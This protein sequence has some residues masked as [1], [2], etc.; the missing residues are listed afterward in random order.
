DLSEK[1]PIYHID[2]AFQGKE[3]VAKIEKACKEAKP[4]ALAFVDMRMPPGWDGLITIERA[5]KIDPDLQVVICTAHADYSWN[6][7]IERLKN[8]N[9]LLILKKPFENIEVKQLARSLTEKWRLISNLND[10]TRKLKS[11][12]ENLAITL[13]S[14]ADAVIATTPDGKI[15]RMNPAAED[16]TGWSEID[17]LQSDIS[18]VLNL[19]NVDKKN[20]V[21]ELTRYVLTHDKTIALS[22]QVVLA[23]RKGIKFNIAGSFAPMKDADGITAGMVIVFR[24]MTAEK[25]AEEVI[26]ELN[27]TLEQRVR[28]RTASLEAANFELKKAKEIADAATIAKSNFLANM[29]HEIRTPMNGIIAAADLALEET[30]T[31]KMEH[32]LKII[33]SSSYSLLGVINDILDFSKIE[34]GKLELENKEF[35]FD[36]IVDILISMFADKVSKKGIEFVVDI[37]SSLPMT[38][39]GDKLRVQQIITNLMGNAYKFTDKHGTIVF[40]IEKTGRQCD[41]NRSE[42]KFSICDTGVGMTSE[43]LAKIF[44]PF[45]QVDSSSTRK[46]GGTGLG[47]SI[48]RQ[49]IEIMGGKI[50]AE[51][52]PGVGT[53]FYF[54]LILEWISERPVLFEIPSD[55]KHLSI[56]VV[57]DSK[58][59]LESLRKTLKSFG[60]VT[61]SASSGAEALNR[62]N[63]SLYGEESFDLIIMDLNMPEMDGIETSRKIRNEIKL[64]TPIVIMNAFGYETT[65][66]TADEGFINGYLSKPFNAFSVFEAIL[67]VFN[68]GG[69]INQAVGNDR[70]DSLSLYK[71][72]IRGLKILVAED[73][74]TNQEIIQAI[75]ESAG[76]VSEI[77]NNGK[78]AVQ[79]LMKEQFDAVLMDMQMPEM[80]GYEAT[81]T[82]REKQEF[83]SLPI[84]ALTAHALKGDEEKCL[85]AGT[86]AYV[87]KPI[88]QDVLFR[89]LYKEL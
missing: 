53:T 2:S 22:D 43:Q 73:N 14:I 54:T 52:T 51:S 8:T 66:K 15:I 55:L 50:W 28:D 82:I 12:Q 40:R 86:N 87:A 83:D 42:L 31:S 60:L 23:T 34:A 35:G 44:Q 37:D 76:I 26:K 5:W 62:L 19:Q 46:Y 17:A 88:Q 78:E 10:Q 89:V 74:L 68:K 61:E 25:K 47:L 65:S 80:D 59:S 7:I 84:I 24:D 45:T 4:Y 33:H 16:L 36:E 29:S 18:V 9:N 67:V 21:R 71:S 77:V 58:K 30:L 41:G 70:A 39:L 75:L 38:M 49:L 11:S 64:N 72:S 81:R 32:F 1:S 13:N 6:Q 85:A 20:Y 3:G 69:L 57:D 63:N 79:A 48:S 56:L 27:R